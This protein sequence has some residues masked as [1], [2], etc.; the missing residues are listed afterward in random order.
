MFFKLPIMRRLKNEEKRETKIG[1]SPGRRSR[2]RRGKKKMMKR[3]Q[4]VTTQLEEGG[5][6]DE[7]KEDEEGI[8]KTDK[9][10][11]KFSGE[12]KEED[13]DHPYSTTLGPD[14]KGKNGGGERRKGDPGRSDKEKRRRRYDGSMTK[15]SLTPDTN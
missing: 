10:S 2:K 14:P 12:G 9:K 11:I 15:I 13:G 3:H 5:R 7:E 6:R 1:N 8:L 4:A